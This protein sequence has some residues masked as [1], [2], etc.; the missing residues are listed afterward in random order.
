MTTANGY[1]HP[2]VLVETSWVA[3]HLNDPKIRLVEVDV[4][5]PPMIPAISLAP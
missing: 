1:A 2:G 5:R 3:E 4:V